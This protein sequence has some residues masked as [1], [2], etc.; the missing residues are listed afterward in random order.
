MTAQQMTASPGDAAYRT[1]VGHTLVCQAC[2]AG[3]ACLTAV[4]LGRAWRAV[5][6]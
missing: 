1:W 4:R 6:T 5:R 3:A 2:R